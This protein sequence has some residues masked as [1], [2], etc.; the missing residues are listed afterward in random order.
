MTLE[1]PGAPGPVHDEG[2]FVEIRRKEPDGM[3]LVA[4]DIF[5]SD[6]PPPAPPSEAT[7]EP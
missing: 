7:S 5:N 4:V 6:L 3:W 2:K 1:V